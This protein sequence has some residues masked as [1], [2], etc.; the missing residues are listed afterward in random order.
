MIN[1]YIIIVTYNGMQWLEKCLKSCTNYPVI[2]VDNASTDETVSFIETN[3]PDVTLFKQD[4]N[5]GFGQANNL[6]IRYALD[7]GTEHVFLLNQDAYLIDSVLDDLVDFQKERPEYGVL[8]PIHI[9]GD[10]KK[11][12]KNFSN[13][14]LKEYSGQFYSDFV[15]GNKL[16]DVYEVPFVNA[17]A[18]LISRKC[19]DTIGGFDPLF[20]HY[21]EDD[22]YCQRVLYHGFKIGVL[23]NIYIIHD[24]SDRVVFKTL[25]FSPEY[26]GNL[27]K[28]YK[29]TYANINSDN[30]LELKIKKLKRT[31]HKLQLQMKYERAQG[32]KKELALLLAI[33][34]LIEKS[35]KVN[36]VY[37]PHYL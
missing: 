37:G 36:K 6:G 29:V 26:Y 32:Y 16:H 33:K 20:F 22:N 31:I 2:I 35:R 13:F 27:E 8:S 7:Q 25:I 34:P 23:P 24:R 3:Y 11:L 30:T 10:Q 15:L 19:L 18:W 21:G 28:G 12:D 17:A 14:M 4:K 9:T 1:T 5:L